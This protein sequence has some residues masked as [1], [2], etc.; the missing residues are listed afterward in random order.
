MTDARGYNHIHTV[1][2][3]ALARKI[4]A[5]PGEDVESE[6][7]DAMQML[8]GTVSLMMLADPGPLRLEEEAVKPKLT[9]MMR[10]LLRLA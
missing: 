6:I 1:F 3:P 9:E 7:R 5:K 10:R 2:V 8:I 4:Q